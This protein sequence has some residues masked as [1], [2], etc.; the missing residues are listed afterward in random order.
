MSVSYQSISHMGLIAL[1]TSRKTVRKV[2]R[3]IWKLKKSQAAWCKKVRKSAEG[4]KDFV[5]DS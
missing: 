1:T 5:P 2:F 3:H 4:K